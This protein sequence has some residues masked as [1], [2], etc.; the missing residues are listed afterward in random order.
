[1]LTCRCPHTLSMRHIP[2]RFI[3]TGLHVVRVDLMNW[4]NRECHLSN[5]GKNKRDCGTINLEWQVKKICIS[6]IYLSSHRH[7]YVF[8]SQFLE[9]PLNVGGCRG[10]LNVL[11]CAKVSTIHLRAFEQ[12]SIWAEQGKNG[13]LS[14]RK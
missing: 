2:F 13:Y 14:W 3:L 8:C 1:M 5:K 12:F 4:K 9:L 6:H 10:G 11:P 7:R